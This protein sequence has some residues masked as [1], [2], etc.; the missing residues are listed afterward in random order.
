MNKM[1]KFTEIVK[2]IAF[3]ATF[4]AIGIILAWRF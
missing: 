4:A 1:E 2:G 3:F